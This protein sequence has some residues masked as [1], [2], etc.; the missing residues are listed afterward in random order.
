VH[1]FAVKKK[2]ERKR[3]N[4]LLKSFCAH[5]NVVSPELVY[6][7]QCD[8]IFEQ[9]ELDDVLQQQFC[10]MWVASSLCCGSWHGKTETSFTH[11]G[12]S[13]GSGFGASGGRG[14]MACE[15]FD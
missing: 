14:N 12:D 5:R 8:G 3:K 15:E 13:V 4:V 9:W 1:I 11:D 7:P 2:K 6:L 10:V